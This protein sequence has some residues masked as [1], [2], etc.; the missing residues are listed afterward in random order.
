ML[1]GRWTVDDLSVDFH[2]VHPVASAGERE[3]S[4]FATVA[5]LHGLWGPPDADEDETVELVRAAFA[6]AEVLVTDKRLVVVFFEGESV[7]GSSGR[8]GPLLVLSLPWERV[9][10]ISRSAKPGFAERLGG[11]EVHIGGVTTTILKLA[12]TPVAR[13]GPAPAY[14]TVG[15]VNVEQLM[16]GLVEA[17]ARWRQTMVAGTDSAEAQ[18]IGAVLAGSLERDGSDLIAWITPPDATH[19]VAHDL[20]IDRTG[21]LRVSPTPV[22]AS[23]EDSAAES[24]VEAEP[25]PVALPA[26]AWYP[27]PTGRFELRYWDGT[28]WTE[29]VSTADPGSSDALVAAPP[30]VAEDPERAA[31]VAPALPD[32]YRR[33]TEWAQR[34]DGADLAE[35]SDDSPEGPPAAGCS[36]PVVVEPTN[37]NNCPACA[38][39]A[40]AD[41]VFCTS[42]GLRLAPAP[43]PAEP[44]SVASEPAPT[45]AA[46]PNQSDQAEVPSGQSSGEPEAVVGVP[47]RGAGYLIVFA[48]LMVAGLLLPFTSVGGEAEPLLRDLGEAMS[49]LVLA[50]VAVVAG[51]AGRAG[52]EAG[53]AAG[54]GVIVVF[55]VAVALLAPVFQGL[56]ELSDAFGTPVT[57]HVGMLA[58]I[59]AALVGFV[60]AFRA[61]GIV[62]RSSRDRQIPASLSLLGAGGTALFLWRVAQPAYPGGPVLSGDWYVDSV[63]FMLA[64]SI[65]VPALFLVMV[66]TGTAAALLGGVLVFPTA[67][68]LAFRLGQ[69]DAFGPSQWRDDLGLAG[70]L[71]ALVVAAI[72]TFGYSDR[73]VRSVTGAR[74]VVPATSAGAT[75][76]AVGLVGVLGLVALADSETSG[77]GT[78]PWAGDQAPELELQRASELDRLAGSCVAGSMSSCDSLYWQSPSGSFHEVIAMECGGRSFG[79]VHRGTCTSTFGR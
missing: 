16:G 40:S 54:A 74:L 15:K 3:A 41:A 62:L 49:V 59:G 63:L 46:F 64:A 75:V 67:T 55:S 35:L 39:P 24:P 48:A 73:A 68:V 5:T 44:V 69:W 13:L 61:F 9:D 18:R 77:V 76:V 66:R 34:Q 31:P 45:G 2:D 21:H 25:A 6:A 1:G 47:L 79:S 42:C 65:A 7:L 27:D 28:R 17:A 22:T 37:T 32:A 52:Y 23:T 20:V 36:E 8:Q 50:G 33:N 71:V 70:I 4:R 10:S 60:V 11:R 53:M 14:A 56:F 51:L 38:N 58:L 43:N 29:H 26:A 72:G 57:P 12:L 30:D 19:Q 78:S